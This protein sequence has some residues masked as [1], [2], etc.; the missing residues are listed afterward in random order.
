MLRMVILLLLS[1]LTSVVNL[2]E[3]FIAFLDTRFILNNHS[4]VLIIIYLKLK[5]IQY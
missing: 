1:R 5:F 3:S 4:I 2:I